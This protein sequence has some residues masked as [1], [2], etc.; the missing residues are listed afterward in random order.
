M[1]PVFSTAVF[2]LIRAESVEN[3]VLQVQV[4]KKKWQSRN[5]LDTNKQDLDGALKAAVNEMSEADGLP[6]SN[7]LLIIE[8]ILLCRLITSRLALL[9]T[10][11]GRMSCL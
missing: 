2:L 8:D 7:C 1:R 6:F 3:V 4:A 9:K 5:A 10:T 11:S